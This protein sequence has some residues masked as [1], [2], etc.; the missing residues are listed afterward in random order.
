MGDLGQPQWHSAPVLPHSFSQNLHKMLK[1]L[2][3]LCNVTFMQSEDGSGKGAA[4]V[5][6]V[7]SR[8]SNQSS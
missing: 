7:H 8:Q 2:A 5:A 4:L 1:D 3:P 6:A